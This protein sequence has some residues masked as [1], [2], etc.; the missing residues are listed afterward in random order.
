[1]RDRLVVEIEEANDNL[2]QDPAFPERAMPEDMLQLIGLY[3]YG[4]RF[5]PHEV[6]NQLVGDGMLE[7]AAGPAS[8]T[9]W[10]PSIRGKMVETPRELGGGVQ[11]GEAVRNKID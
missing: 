5:R 4:L 6:A 3:E 2:Q 9:I 10:T 1:M 11:P 8:S 7:G